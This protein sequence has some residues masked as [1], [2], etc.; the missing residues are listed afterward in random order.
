M[1]ACCVENSTHLMIVAWERRL[2]V[3]GHCTGTGSSIY[4][5]REV[6]L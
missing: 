1:I 2:M 6:I 5:H 3:D 4:T